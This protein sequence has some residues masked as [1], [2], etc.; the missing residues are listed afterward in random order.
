M[1]EIQKYPKKL[2]ALQD[3]VKSLSFNDAKYSQNTSKYVKSNLERDINIQIEDQEEYIISLEKITL[4]EE[5]KASPNLTQDKLDEEI[6]LGKKE[7]QEK[8]KRLQDQQGT[9]NNHPKYQEAVAREQRLQELEKK[10]APINQEI[11]EIEE[12]YNTKFKSQFQNNQDIAIQADEKKSIGL[13]PLTFFAISCSVAAISIFIMG[14]S[15]IVG[16]I[17][18]FCSFIC[19]CCVAVCR[20]KQNNN[21]MDKANSELLNNTKSWC[22]RVDKAVIAVNILE[23]K[24]KEECKEKPID[25]EALGKQIDALKTLSV[26]ELLRTKRQSLAR[27]TA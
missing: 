18:A 25:L 1:Q 7:R 4:L 5:R 13:S 2:S 24:I 6:N 20:E 22:A 19:L 23:K 27:C 3:K 14:A 11:Q 17:G 21:R 12:L 9:L 15:L 16:I 8:I 10:F 26:S